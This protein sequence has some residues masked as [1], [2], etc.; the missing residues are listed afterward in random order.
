MNI[1]KAFQSSQVRFVEHPEGKY[2]FGIVALDLAMI[3]ESSSDGSRIARSVDPS[4]KG[5]H[6]VETPGGT[7]DVIVIWEPGVYELL[8]KSR[9]PKAKPFKKWLFEEVLPTIRATGKYE[10]APQQEKELPPDQILGLI[11]HIFKN[12]PIRPELVAGVKL[13]AA[14]KLAPTAAL[15]LEESRQLLITNT[16]QAHEL[17]T[18]TEIGKELG[19][20]GQA[21][22]K[23]LIQ[24]GLQVKNENRKSQ[25][26]PAYLPTVQGSEF[27]DLTLATAATNSGTFQ[28]LRWYKSVIAALQ[29]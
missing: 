4:Y 8:S 24:K 9:K 3:L 25:K 27:A 26:E 7:Q 19:L 15:A 6:T 20:S 23:L 2:A 12:V 28:Q 21:V 22:N 14:K 10:V 5:L 11:D 1:V 29:N 17:L 16:A 13:N 18:A